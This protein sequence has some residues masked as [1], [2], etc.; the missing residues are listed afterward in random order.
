MTNTYRLPTFNDLYFEQIGRRDLKPERATVTSAG[1]VIE[2][3]IG[4]MNI[5]FYA[6]VYNSSV[7]DRIMAVPGK[8]TAIWM[9]KNIG[10]VVTHG[11]ETGLEANRIEGLV[12]PAVRLSYT[13]QR[14]MDKSDDRSTTWNHQLPYT[15][16]HSASAV[17]WIETPVVNV[18]CNLIYSGEYYS[19]GYNGPEYLM[20]SYYELGCTLWKSFSVKDS[21]I[22]LKAEC[23]NLTDYRYELVTNYPMPGRQLRLTATIDL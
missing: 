3:G 17:A 9:M 2:N 11:L 16:R 19:N 13:Y 23:I 10:Q 8:N 6:D 14:A 20:P 7:K 18:S 1:M 15:P 5:S 4:N 21:P 12:R 22:T